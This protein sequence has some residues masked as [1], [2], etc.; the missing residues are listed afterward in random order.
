M[1]AIDTNV[2]MYAFVNKA[3]PELSRRAQRAIQD[4]APV[5]VN[6]IV[7]TEFVW[8]C[9]TFYD[10]KRLEIHARLEAIAAAPEFQFAQPQA[11]VMVAVGDPV[12]EFIKRFRDL[13][14]SPRLV[15]ISVVNPEAVTA[16]VGQAA[17]RGMGFS[18]VFPYP[19][20]DTV[21][22]VRDIYALAAP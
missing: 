2:L 16:K 8:A 15:S 11:V 13:A 17:T 14:R 21:P 3:D 12:Y 6:D 10:M 18:Q 4:N 1:I 19:Y 20:N 7:L 22:L 5:F 9:R